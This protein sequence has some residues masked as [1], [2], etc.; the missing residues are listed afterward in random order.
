MLKYQYYQVSSQP[1]IF[2]ICYKNYLWYSTSRFHKHSCRTI[3]KA[4]SAVGSCWHSRYILWQMHH[5]DT[6]IAFRSIKSVLLWT[7]GAERQSSH[8][9]IIA[10]ITT[11]RQSSKKWPAISW[12]TTV[13]DITIS[14]A[15]RRRTYNR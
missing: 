4:T 14:P 13:C 10:R 12:S 6:I 15:F 3:K 9:R 5:R 7:R 11:H 1:L 2:L 8:V